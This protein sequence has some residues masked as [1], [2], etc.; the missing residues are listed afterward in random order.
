M[1]LGRLEKHPLVVMRFWRRTG[2]GLAT[3]AIV[4]GVC[5]CGLATGG[6]SARSGA[7]TS[8]PIGAQ[9]YVAQ[10]NRALIV[11]RSFFGVSTEYWTIPNWAKHLRLLRK[12][13]S[14][15]TQEGPV[16]LRIGGNSAD[17]SL[18]APS[19]ELPEWQ[20]ELTPSWLAQVRDIVQRLHVK[21][22]LD[23]N[24]LTATP[25][26]AAKW[27]A[28]A[29]RSLPSGSIIGF[30]IG[31]EPDIYSP[32]LMPAPRGARLRPRLTAHS[33][34]GVYASYDQHLD[35][36]VPQIPLMGP[37]LAEPQRNVSWISTLLASAHHGLTAITAHRYPLSACA[38]SGPKAP[39]IQRV[40]SEDATAG[41]AATLAPAI[42]LARHAHLPLRLTEFN[43]VTCGGTQ[44]VSDTFATA[45]W[46][47]DAL[48]ELIHAGVASAALHVRANAINTAFSLTSKGLVAYPLLYGLVVYA[49]TLGSDPRLLPT[50]LRLTNTNRVKVWAVLDRRQLRILMIN[51][52]NH[53]IRMALR[54]PSVGA[55]TVQRL[56]APSV[57]SRTR[58]TLNGQ[59]LNSQGDWSGAATHELL[60]RTRGAYTLS[61]PPTS[62][63]VVSATAR[64]GT[65]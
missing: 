63:A 34:A 7:G 36:A 13:F 10:R 29:E 46:A 26:Q 22:I 3:V 60:S 4:A 25:A 12:V 57:G 30:E 59:S 43:S 62:A 27:A 53:P 44:G 41:M 17:Q 1:P 50:A 40:L 8:R 18:W 37:A 52:G 6:T 5:A 16:V 45:L 39:S 33:Y 54:I 23:L 24:L 56:L 64:A 35:G 32:A 48:F 49:R 38:H 31:N 55:A 58:V 65:T 19:K 47:P 20:F 14:M 9:V 21:L 42:R 28:T 11:P 15:V 61:L 2:V 51:K